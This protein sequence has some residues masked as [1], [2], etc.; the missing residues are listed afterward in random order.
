MEID[1]NDLTDAWDVLGF[2]SISYVLCLFYVYLSQPPANGLRSTIFDADILW[3]SPIPYVLDTGLDI[4]AKGVILRAFDQF[5]IKSCIDFKPRKSE[6]YFLS[7]QKLN[8]CFSYIGQVFANGQNLSI[9][10]SCDHLG[11][12]EHEILHALGFYHEQSR[13]DR[14]DHIKIVWDNIKEGWEYNFRKVGHENSTT[15]E[16]S[17]DYL[18]VMHYYKS[19]FTNGNGSTII[20]SDPKFQDVIGQRLEMSPGDVQELNLLY[21]C[22]S[23][24]AF[25]L[26]CGFSNG[27][28]C[29]M[30][31]CTKNGNGW[32]VV[33]QVDGGPSSDHTS[34]PSENGEKGQEEGFFIHASTASG[35]EGDSARLETQTISPERECNVQ[36]L[37]FYYFHSGNESDE[38]NIWIREFQDEQDTTGILRLMDQIT[39]P[40]TSHWKLHHVSLN[41]TEQFQVVFEVRKGTENSTGGFSIDDINLSE[42][43]CPHL[44]W[45][46]DDLEERLNNTAYGTVKYSPQQYSKEGY[47]YRVAVVLNKTYVGIFMQLLSGDFDNE[48]EWPC[49]QKQ[50]TFQLLDQNPNMQQRMSKQKSFTTTSNKRS[51]QGILVWDNPCKNG[52]EVLLKNNETACGGILWGYRYFTSLKEL[53]SRDFLK[54]GCAI[55]MFNFED[56]TPLIHGNTLPC[57]EVRPVNITR[58]PTNLFEGQC[59]TRMT[60]TIS[61]PITTEDKSIFCFSPGMVASPVIIFLL[62]LLLLA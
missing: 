38:L 1:E 53:Q 60:S 12:V 25:K 34:L 62:T 29:Q 18:S 37:Q 42:T 31:R 2:H 28:M 9:G 54:G 46:F 33:T 30:K 21:K 20:T 24:V 41:A 6:E 49:L 14:S 15:H 27:T 32:E 45:Q 36:C 61:P 55:F 7:I 48:L 22:K 5:R 39:G 40:P 8:G 11:I 59:S 13:Y 26:Y 3:T 4:N 35:Q 44:V 10:S 57:S 43:E 50:I 51:S 58:P 56:L 19:A 52:T 17:Y 47:A 23:F 16:T